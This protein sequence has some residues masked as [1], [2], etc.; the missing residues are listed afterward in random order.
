[1]KEAFL[2][3][4]FSAEMPA[5][6][7]IRFWSY[8]GP[9]FLVIA[10]AFIALQISKENI[11]MIIAACMGIVLCW[12]WAL[13]GFVAALFTLFIVALWDFGHAPIFPFWK[14]GLNVAISFSLLI[15]ALAQK[16]IAGLIAAS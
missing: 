5:V 3:K 9:L 1:M 8:L 16:E 10:F 14:V 11:G 13:R 6:A 12:K 7:K 15:I 4:F 2:S